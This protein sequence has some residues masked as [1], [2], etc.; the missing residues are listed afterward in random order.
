VRHKISAAS[1]AA[2]AI[3]KTRKIMRKKHGIGMAN[4]K[5]KMAAAAKEKASMAQRKSVIS[6]SANNQP[7]EE[8]DKRQHG[9]QW[10]AYK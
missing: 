7:A 9:W 3:I 4:R 6:A 2:A 8:I 1:L 10:L 5:R